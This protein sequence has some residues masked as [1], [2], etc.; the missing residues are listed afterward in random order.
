MALYVYEVIK[1]NGK[2]GKRFEVRQKMTDPPFKKHPETG[3]PVRRIIFA[4]N[5]PKL[6]YDRAIKHLS[7][8]DK[9]FTPPP[10]SI[11]KPISPMSI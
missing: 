7:K 2:P 8:Q 11:H 6:K 1:P 3:E 9:K 10:D 5:T 4:P